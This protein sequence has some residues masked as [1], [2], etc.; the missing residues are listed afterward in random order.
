[1]IVAMASLCVR[2]EETPSPSPPPEP[3]ASQSSTEGSVDVGLG[4]VD[5]LGESSKAQ[6]Y[7]EIPNGFFIDL[8]TFGAEKAG[9]SIELQADDALQEDQRWDL[10]VQKPGT[11]QIHARY[12]QIPDWYSNTSLT[13]FANAGGGRMLFPEPIRAEVQSVPG[14]GTIGPILDSALA[15]AQ[16]YPQ[17]RTRRDTAS[18][19][20][21]WLT[22][23]KGLT[24]NAGYLQAQRNGTHRVSMATD[25]T[26][27]ADVTEF[28]GDTDFTSRQAQVGLDYAR[29]RWNVGGSIVWSEFTNGLTSATGT[30]TLYNAYVVDNPMRATDGTPS[31]PDPGAD[32]NRAAAQ[33][34]L[35]APPDSQAT[36]LNL[37]GGVRI[38]D[39]GR[40]S[41][42][43]AVGQNRQDEAFLPFTLNTAIVPPTPLVVLQDGVPVNSYDGKIDITRWDARV[44]G[45]PIRWF[46][47]EAFVHDYDYNNKTSEYVT[48]DWVNADVELAGSSVI[49]EPF[50]YETL[51][52]GGRV[53]FHPVRGL[54]LAA[55]AGRVTFDRT[56][57]FTPS[58]DEDL[59][60]L[61][62]G[63]APAAWG[64]LRLAYAHGKRRYD[65]YDEDPPFNPA[66]T[67]NFDLS[68]RDRDQISFLATFTPIERL[69][70]GVQAQWIEDD[71]PSTVFGVTSDKSESWA[72]DFAVDAG[73]GVT[74]S[75][76]YGQDR[77]EWSMASQLRLIPVD[78]PA[79]NWFTDTDDTTHNCG[80]GVTAQ[81]AKGKVVLFFHGNKT[82]A[83]GEQ[84][85]SGVAVSFPNVTSDLTVVDGSVTWK[86]R[87]S[88][89]LI[90]AVT[91][92]DWSENNFQLDPMIP[93]M[94][95]VDGG[96]DE[97]VFLGARVPG[98]DYTW[99]RVL[100]NYTF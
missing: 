27:G 16:P 61:S 32:N 41:F 76:D 84:T 24:F 97:S 48:P 58:T 87:P 88:M 67:Q 78:N 68:N 29:D 96:A 82:D 30:S 66:G 9:W 99:A 45:Q 43:F 52:Y 1:V 77:F 69:D 92:E 49:A 90:F 38:A 79:N 37:N 89:G 17:L 60:D 20:V 46:S 4:T 44:S 42:E 55:G 5:H 86:L 34:L 95:G 98:Y 63:W 50:A 8:F 33:L 21:T 85:G 7:R 22:P 54:S 3:A 11:L 23:V 74:V 19:D 14:L 59:Y 25:F 39:W 51:S 72:I 81:L 6:E 62:V 93:W 36:W 15:A 47:F 31:V 70:L 40:A 53:T 80:L 91:Y 64:S 100:F 71:Y 18:A 94:G 2:A 26:I 73:S 56:F 83:T 10:E 13:L 75:G 28:A 12:D 65:E 35:S 57:R